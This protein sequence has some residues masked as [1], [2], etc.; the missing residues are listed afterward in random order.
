MTKIFWITITAQT[1]QAIQRSTFNE[2]RYI[3][4]DS[5]PGPGKIYT[6]NN[7]YLRPVVA[8]SNSTVIFTAVDDGNGGDSEIPSDVCPLYT[9]QW[10]AQ[11][12][13]ASLDC[14][15]SDLYRS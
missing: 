5:F 9:G 15:G 7:Y 10:T 3:A 11:E 12:S 14:P 13:E 6:K 8:W 2:F 1:C 4:D